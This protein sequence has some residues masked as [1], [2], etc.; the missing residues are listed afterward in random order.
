MRYR[1]EAALTARSLPPCARRVEPGQYGALG[2]K[3]VFANNKFTLIQRTENVGMDVAAHNITLE[4]M[5]AVGRLR[6]GGTGRGWAC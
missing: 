3:Q 6:W 5:K 4:Y 2:I 1:Q